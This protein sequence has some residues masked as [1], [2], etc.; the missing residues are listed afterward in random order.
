MDPFATSHFSDDA[1]LH[2]AKRLLG[3]GFLTDAMLLTR[4]TEIDGRQLYRREGYASMYSYMTEEWRLT[5]DAAY[6]RIHAARAAQRFPGV[7]IALAD[8]RLHMRGVL[9]LARHLTSANA[10][11]LVAAATHK[12]RFEIQQLLAERFPQPDLPERLQTIGSV[13]PA[14]TVLEPSSGLM[15]QLAPEQ[16]QVTIPEQLAH[17]Q[18]DTL[19]GELT[20]TVVPERLERPAPA[21]RVTPLAPN[22]FGFQC[23]LDQESFDLLQRARALMSHQNPAGEIAPVLKR[24]LAL[25]VGQLEKQKFAATTRPGPAKPSAS[26]RHIPAAVKRAV[27]ERDRDRCAFVSDGGRRCSARRMLE[28]D[29]K[30]PIARGGEAT[31]DNVRILCAA[32]NAYAAERAFGADFMDRKRRE[33]REQG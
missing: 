20:R 11:E 19:P 27:R 3:Q 4:I 9:M 8:G 16:V 31:V 22:R 17:G 12:S 26:A 30:E 13:P 21:Q 6:K 29:H 23:T 5:E 14:T 10:D 2:D 18:A 28:F 32:H 1:L 15:D 24:A 33:A 7:L 25:L